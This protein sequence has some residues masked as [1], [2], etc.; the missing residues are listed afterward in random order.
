MTDSE[1]R[2]ILLDLINA[3][4]LQP[5]LKLIACTQVR[6]AS[7]K[8]IQQAVELFQSVAAAFKAGDPQAAGAVMQ[9]AGMPPAIAEKIL[10]EF[11]AADQKQ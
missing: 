1:A 4:T 7:G 2:Q 11:H 6:M 10:G 5:A 9:K 3:T 8:T